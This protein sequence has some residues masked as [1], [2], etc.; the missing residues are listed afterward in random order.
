MGKS[1]IGVLLA[2]AISWNFVDTDVMIQVAEEKGLQEII[3][4]EGVEAFA[5]IEQRH[6]V[7]LD[8][9]RT[10]IAAGGSVVHGPAAMQHLKAMGAVVY[11]D[12]PLPELEKR[13]ANLNG[14]G[15]LMAPG[16]TLHGLFQQRQPLY[17]NYADLVIHC[18]YRSHEQIVDEII[19]RL[20]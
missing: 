12:L 5:R 20:G 17:R 13:L 18:A 16:Q 2:K 4:A 1:T 11:L 7:A 6:V 19:V 14:R 10:V 15:I 9:R 8:R 3:H